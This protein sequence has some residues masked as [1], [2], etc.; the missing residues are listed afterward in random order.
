MIF[1]CFTPWYSF[2]SLIS[3]FNSDDGDIAVIVGG[4]TPFVEARIKNFTMED[5]DEVEGEWRR[6]EM[7][8]PGNAGLLFA[9]LVI[10][11][12]TWEP[13]QPYMRN[14]C[15]M[16]S[17]SSAYHAFNLSTLLQVSWIATSLISIKIW[18]GEKA[19]Q[20]AVWKRYFCIQSRH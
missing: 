10:N 8:Q 16:K 17:W 3:S 5:S 20:A 13:R 6:M 7:T 4:G 14:I 2:V 11:L 19:K 1:L 9:V 15:R 18:G 12:T